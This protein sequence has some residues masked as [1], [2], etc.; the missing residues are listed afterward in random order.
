M[1]SVFNTGLYDTID[2]HSKINNQKKVKKK[3]KKRKDKREKEREE[4]ND[5]KGR[6]ENAMKVVSC[7]AFTGFS[8]LY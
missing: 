4:Q 6:K 1:H 5:M 8:N 2:L 3:K 7:I